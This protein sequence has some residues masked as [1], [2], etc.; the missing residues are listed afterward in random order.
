MSMKIYDRY[1]GD[2]SEARSRYMKKEGN[3]RFGALM[4]NKIVMGV[5]LGCL[6][7]LEVILICRGSSDPDIQQIMIYLPILILVI[8][9]SFLGLRQQCDA[10]IYGME[11]GRF[12]LLNTMYEVIRRIAPGDVR[13]IRILPAYRP[14]TRRIITVARKTRYENKTW[15]K[16]VLE[17]QK[18]ENHAGFAY[19][20][21]AVL[22]TG[23]GDMDWNV[24]EDA[25]LFRM[26]NAGYHDLLDKH[27]AI[28]PCGENADPFIYLLQH[29]ACPVIISRRMYG[30][31]K[32]LMDELFAR[33]GM[34]M[35]RLRIEA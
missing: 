20:P 12:L 8:F 26:Q 25:A 2:P 3:S 29:S 23:K 4:Q 10:W 19:Y 30:L 34:D 16:P 18:R 6:G 31:H 1:Y 28:V 33:S 35:K 9:L 17:A 13:E 27:L 21:M 7:V 32:G 15:F 14:D 11:D 5:V 22:Y 24:L